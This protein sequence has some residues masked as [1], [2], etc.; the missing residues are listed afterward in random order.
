M[1][2]LFIFTTLLVLSS[3]INANWFSDIRNVFSSNDSVSSDPQ[4]V[5]S[6]LTDNTIANALKQALLNGASDVI[7][8]LSNSGG[9]NQDETIRIPFPD[10]LKI[11]Q[12][13]LDKIGMGGS[14]SEL[15]NKLNQ[16]AELAT[17]KARPLFVD[18]IKALSW[19]DVRTLLNGPDDD[20]TRYFQERMSDPL[21]SEMMAV[22]DESLSKVGAVKAYNSVMNSYN[23]LPFVPQIDADLSNHVTNRGIAGIFYYHAIEEKN[24][25]NN[26]A[27][28][29]T[30]LLREV[31]SD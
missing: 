3:Q 20:A 21:R 28:R 7:N 25:R 27:K 5:Q 11:V 1:L 9:F 30:E 16:A 4:N 14:L 2:K 15:E 31:F 17:V 19:S 12:T 10:S 22:V 8:Q 26:P 24:I 6:E 13:S 23:A 18:A 29:T